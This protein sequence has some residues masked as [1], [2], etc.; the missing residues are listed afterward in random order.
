MPAATTA[1]I[2]IRAGPSWRIICEKEF[3]PGP[4]RKKQERRRTGLELDDW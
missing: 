2:A 4:V 1:I 3:T